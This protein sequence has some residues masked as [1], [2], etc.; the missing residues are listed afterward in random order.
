MPLLTASIVTISLSKTI[1]N[2]YSPVKVVSEVSPVP[3]YILHSSED[4]IIDYYHAERL[5]QAAREP[6]QLIALEAGHNVTF[7][8]KSNRQQLVDVLDQAIRY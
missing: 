1:S 7:R 8:L 4:E 3:I 6:K 2:T 5:Y